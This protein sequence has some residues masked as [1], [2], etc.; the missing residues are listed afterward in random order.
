[1]LQPPNE[2]PD[3]TTKPVRSAIRGSKRG[4]IFASRCGTPTDLKVT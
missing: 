1:M 2:K 3:E 4:N